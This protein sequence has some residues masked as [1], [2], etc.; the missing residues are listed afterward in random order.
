MYLLDTDVLSFTSPASRLSGEEVETWR[1]WVR[2]NQEQLFI[3][4]VTIMEIRFGVERLRTK[5]AASKCAALG[6][7][8]LI[9]E[10]IYRDRIV[11]VSPEIAN[12][13]GALLALAE[14]TGVKPGAEDALIAASAAVSGYM[15]VTRN[16]R[17]MR[18]FGV[19]HLNPLRPLLS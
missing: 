14:H 13:A 7:W 17:H 10:T 5:G 4:A 12:Q 6:K 3:S 1:S 2:S 9:T 11:W 16:E 18:A 19:E 15:L 8:L